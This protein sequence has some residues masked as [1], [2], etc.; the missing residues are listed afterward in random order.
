MPEP[1]SHLCS[2]NPLREK[3][4]LLNA[5]LSARVLL[6][7][8]GLDSA[9][10]HSCLVLKLFSWFSLAPERV[11]PVPNCMALFLSL[12]LPVYHILHVDVILLLV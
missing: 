3:R 2:L 8:N 7:F 6:I 5:L 9:F 12:P 1:C 4:F 10:W 11:K